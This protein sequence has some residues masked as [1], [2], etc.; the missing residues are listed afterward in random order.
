MTR[1]QL[2]GDIEALR[3]ELILLRKDHDQVGPGGLGGLGGPWDTELTPP[4]PQEVQELRAQVSQSALT[5]E[6]DAP[7]SQDLGKVLGELRAQ[8]DALAQKNLEDLE[9]QWGQQ[10]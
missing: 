9:K 4:C 2:E 3:E 8:Y 10:V 7:R 6:V 1:L 5:V